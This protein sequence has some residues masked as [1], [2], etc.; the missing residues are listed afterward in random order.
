[1]KDFG[2]Q[3]YTVREITN[4]KE[5][6]AKVF[7]Q[8]RE[9]GYTEIQRS[10]GPAG[11][12]AAEY[13]AAADAAGLRI[14]GTHSSF[15]E[16]LADPDKAMDDHRIMGTTN[17][18]V[19]AMPVEYRNS[20][21]GAKQFVEKA[22]RL[23]EIF[24]KNGFKFTYHNHSFE[25]RRYEGGERPMD[26]LVREL[27]PDSTSFVLDTYWCQ[28]AGVN[29]V[30]WIEKLTGRIDI[31]HLKDMAM[32]SDAEKLHETVF[33]EIGQGNIEF[34]PIIE[35]SKRA[36]VKHFVVE[37]D[38]FFRDGDQ[39]KSARLSAEAMKKL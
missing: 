31:L 33:A 26:I 13:R 37:Q 18:G 2:L 11:I 1:M 6:L 25:Y 20:L 16:M 17:I 28:N 14:V 7:C 15:D 19:G 22:N 10:G 36:G 38:N 12:T 24:Y 30:T 32:N 34:I 9:I 5:D 35:A 8:L 3:T 4:T 29:P 27:N 23:S 21:D 39:L